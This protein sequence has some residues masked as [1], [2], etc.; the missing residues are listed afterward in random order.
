MGFTYGPL[1]TALAELLPTQVRYTG[2][3][4][5]SNPAGIL[6]ASL[7]P[8]AATWLAVH[9]G[10]EAV[11][12]YLTIAAL[13]SMIALVLMLSLFGGD[14]APRHPSLQNHER[15]CSIRQRAQ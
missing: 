9:H 13:I 2:A 7:A 8:Y 12:Y 14:S 11:G 15:P 5:S 4:L 3:S 1:G 6:G 10:L